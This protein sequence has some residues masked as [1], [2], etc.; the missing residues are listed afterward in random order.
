MKETGP[1]APGS[2]LS[3]F[4]EH[5][6]AKTQSSEFVLSRSLKQRYP[7]HHVVEFDSDD[8]ELRGF[9]DAGFASCALDND[10]GGYTAEVGYTVSQ[11]RLYHRTDPGR[12]NAKPYFAKYRYTWQ[13]TE[14]L[15]YIAS[16]SNARGYPVSYHFLLSPRSLNRDR[17][18]DLTANH[19]TPAAEGLLQ[20]ASMWTSELHEEVYVFDSGHWSKS[21]AL[22]KSTEAATW[23]DVVLDAETKRGLIED[24]EGFFDSQEL[25]AEFEVPWKRGVILHGLPGNGKTITIKAL[26][27][28]LQHR[29]EPVPSLYVKSFEDMCSGPQ[30]AIRGIFRRARRM[31]PCLLIFED[32]DS[33]ITD[34][35]RSYFLNE[36]D[37]LEA[38]DGILMVGS[39]NH[40]DRLDPAIRDRPSR[41][42]RKYYFRLP[43]AA[44]RAAYARF[45][46][47]KLDARPRRRVEFPDEA[48]E[49]IASITDGFSFAYL[50]ELFIAALLTVARG[51]K[52][53]DPVIPPEADTPESIVVVP[54]G[55]GDDGEEEAGED[56]DEDSSGEGGN[57]KDKKKEKI[58]K[59]KAAELRKRLEAARARHE[60]LAKIE[61]PENLRDNLLIK[62][63]RQQLY[64]LLREM[65]SNEVAAVEENEDEKGRVNAGGNTMIGVVRA[66]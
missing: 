12:F 60:A 57:A 44:E 4:E 37:G 22:W 58:K 56:S 8:C 14:F 16:A 49:F 28:V 52:G 11:F 46:K 1:I 32:L 17:D 31:A 41:F 47:A 9:A 36:V 48:C 5:C 23:D 63:V 18:R 61:V 64:T 43:G 25:Y 2:F 34:K 40:L 35:T 24:I 39:T 26:M 20:A 55:G 19:L 10:D 42:D 6:S 3:D 53:G 30:Y 27:A 45:W 13:D 51:G 7:G 59:K 50:K 21:T 15:Y 66:T 65:D 62:V 54:S 33:L 38:N 29:A